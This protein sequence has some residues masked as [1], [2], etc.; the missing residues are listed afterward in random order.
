MCIKVSK[1]T[2]CTVNRATP[3]RAQRLGGLFTGLGVA[4][5]R[6]CVWESPLSPVHPLL[7]QS[8]FPGV[9]VVILNKRGYR[10]LEGDG[11]K[12]LGL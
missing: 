2:L 5:G 4:G 3:K 12:D 7:P 1:R 9:T 8:Y 10:L 6:C 11:V